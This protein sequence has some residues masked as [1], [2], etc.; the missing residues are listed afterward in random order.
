MINKYVFL[1]IDGV[2][3]N[4]R[5]NK[6]SMCCGIRAKN[7]KQL[8]II[9]DKHDPFFVI[10]SAWRYLLLGD[11]MNTA[12]FKSMLL[13]HGVS[14]KMK[15]L[16]FTRRDIG[17]TRTS[18]REEGIAER[19][20]QITEW[21]HKQHMEGNYKAVVIDDLPLI[22]VEKAFRKNRGVFVQTVSN[23]GLT[24]K[25]VSVIDKFLS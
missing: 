2:L 15:I 11:Y 20:A 7:V 4:H 9:I 24:P 1:D 13:T 23:Q 8:N 5:F 18:T 25:E 21:M 17:I 6:A 10:S 12:G 14:L 3:N 22:G 19:I 16:S